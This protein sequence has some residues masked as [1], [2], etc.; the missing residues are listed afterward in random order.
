MLQM[1]TAIY[2]AAVACLLAHSSV[3]VCLCDLVYSSLGYVFK[4]CLLEI[5]M[6]IVLCSPL[7]L[8]YLYRFKWQC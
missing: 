7:S 3:G 6:A 2:F 8:L 5:A 1:W 4:T